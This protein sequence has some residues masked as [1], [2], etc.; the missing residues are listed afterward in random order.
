[1]N[2]MIVPKPIRRKK[3]HNKWSSDEVEATMRHLKQ[4]IK[5]KK[6]PGK[7]LCEQVL[8]KEPILHKRTA[9]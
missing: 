5:M 6:K 8:R 4:F 7:A 2:L 3:T 9:N 1:M